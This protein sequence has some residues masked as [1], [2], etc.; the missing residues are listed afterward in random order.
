MND[1]YDDVDDNDDQYID[2]GNNEDDFNTLIQ[3]VKAPRSN[4]SSNIEW[5]DSKYDCPSCS[6]SGNYFHFI[7]YLMIYNVDNVIKGLLIIL[8]S[9]YLA[10]G[11]QG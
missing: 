2:D 3:E 9:V 5:H 7:I 8:N 10:P 11:E 6:Y 1:V 4:T